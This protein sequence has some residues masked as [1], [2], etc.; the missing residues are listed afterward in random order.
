MSNALQEEKTRW[1]QYNFSYHFVWIPKYKKKILTGEVQKAVKLYI[2]EAVFR[3]NWKFIALETDINHVYC[4]ISTLP[5]DFFFKIVVVLKGY[6]P[7]Q[8]GKQFPKL[9]KISYKYGIWTSSYY[10]G[11]AGNVSAQTITRYINESQ[12]N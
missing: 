8:L 6:S 4:F 7:I 9:K 5:K 10:I 2:E 3:N 11:T 1:A 12:G